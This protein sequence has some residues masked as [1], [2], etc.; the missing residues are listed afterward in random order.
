M[1]EMR[2]VLASER[3]WAMVFLLQVGRAA[4]GEGVGAGIVVES[5]AAEEVI[6]VEDG[7]GVDDVGVGGG[8]VMVWILCALI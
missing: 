7:G 1:S 6:G 4:V 2:P 8:E 3:C 5:V